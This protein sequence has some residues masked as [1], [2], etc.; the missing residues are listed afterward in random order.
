[1][2]RHALALALALS[3]SGLLLTAQSPTHPHLRK[4]R[5]ATRLIV[6]GRPFLIRGGELGNSSASNLEYLAPHWDR[7]RA[8]RLNTILA[9]VYWELLQPEEG[10]FD[11]TLVDGLIAEA[12]TR[13]MKLVLL[14]FGSWKNSMSCYAP[15]WVKKDQSRFPRSVDASGRSVEILSPFS[16]VNRDTDARA[17]ATLMKHLKAFDGEANTVVMVQV[18]N[19]I[20]MIPDAR[21]HSEQATKSFASAV[22]ADLIAY[23]VKNT[24]SLTAEL[25]ELWQAA[26]AKRSG[27]W[28]EVFGDG[29]AAEELFMAWHFARFTQQVAAA[30]KAEYPLPMFVNAA[31]IRPGYKP[32]QYPS[33]GPLPHLLDVWRAGA[34]AIDFIAPDIYFPTFV[35]WTRRY[36]RG[37]NPLFIPEALRNPDAA[38]NALYAFAEHDAIG[39]SPFAIES[40]GEPGAG[41]LTRTYDLVDQLTPLIL[42]H[43][44][45]G[46][47]AG[48]IQEHPD[49]RQPQQLRLN[50]YTLSASFERTSP[51]SLADGAAGGG[52]Q[53]APVT[54]PAGGLVIATGPDEFLFAG[55]GVTIT[56][57]SP[58]PGWQTGILSVE[59]GRFENGRWKNIRWLNGDETHQGRHLRLVPGGLSIQRIKLYRYK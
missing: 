37:G 40:I 20:G 9:P 42:E 52:A 45:R 41:L 12:R 34:P 50:G 26:G 10:K 58:K 18:E 15:A 48:L 57:A 53:G 11:F 28:T 14:W 16:T 27:T 43:Q 19:E 32:G 59:E 31:L 55:I 35:E 46:T 36:V 8:M 3:I 49:N 44:G 2:N 1:V 47:M 23:L 17:F 7:F 13:D 39:F 30:G 51:P 22:P 54:W 33:A 29:A 25:R 6:G 4:E 5:G 38:V 24:E 56:F 21:D